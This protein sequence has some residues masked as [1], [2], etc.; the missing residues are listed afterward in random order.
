MNLA[1]MLGYADIKQLSRIAEAYRCEC[2]GHSKNELIQSILSTV[3]RKD[4]FDSQVGSLTIE[5]LR[6][7]NHL[8]FESREAFSLEELLARAQQSCFGQ[9]A[10]AEAKPPEKKTAAKRARKKSEPEPEAPVPRD[11]INRFRHQGWLFNGYSGTGKYLFQV[12]RDLKAR[13]RETL[14]WKFA[15]ELTYTDDPH[16]YRDEQGLMQDDVRALLHY[17]YHNEVQLAADGTMYKRFVLQL[18]DRLAIREELP[19]KGAWRFGYGKYFNVYPNRFSLLFDYC[20]QSKF[21]EDDGIRLALTA[22]GEERLAVKP[23][24]EQIQ[25]YKLWLKTY[26]GPIPNLHSLVH[27]INYLAEQWV[28]ADSLSK[29]LLPLIKPYYYD[30]AETILEQRIIVMMVHLGLL[31]I[32]EHERHGTVIRMTKAGSSVV[33]GLAEPEYVS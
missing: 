12:P 27:W 7:L 32:G 1:D 20:R 6:F 16:V 21:L 33:A 10:K 2:S 13:F 9:T 17:I 26:K 5:D 18:L 23:P 30:D 11:I 4:V 25:L 3:S 14:R 19:P 22:A 8:L 28:T 24:G 15:E 29:V 31:R